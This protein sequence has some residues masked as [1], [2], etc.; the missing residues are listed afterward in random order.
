MVAGPGVPHFRSVKMRVLKKY[1][2][3]LKGESKPYFQPLRV[4]RMGMFWVFS[5]Y[6]PGPKTSATWPLPN[7]PS[8]TMTASWPSRTVSL[9]PILISF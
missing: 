9:A 5:S 8:L 4:V 2:S 3:A 7:W 6:M 1:T